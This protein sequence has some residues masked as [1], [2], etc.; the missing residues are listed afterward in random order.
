VDWRDRVKDRLG[1]K[2]WKRNRAAKSKKKRI[3]STKTD[4]RAKVT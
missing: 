2:V 1:S 4:P 3:K